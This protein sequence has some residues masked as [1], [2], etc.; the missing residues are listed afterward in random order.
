MSQH[1]HDYTEESHRVLEGRVHRYPSQAVVRLIFWAIMAIYV[2]AL[3]WMS[4]E[5][6]TKWLAGWMR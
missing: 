2:G 6:G 3:W 5:A 4:T 1:W